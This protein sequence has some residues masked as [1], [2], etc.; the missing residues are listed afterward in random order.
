MQSWFYFVSLLLIISVEFLY[1]VS[2]LRTNSL[3]LCLAASTHNKYLPASE[4]SPNANRNIILNVHTKR[5]SHTV[6]CQGLPDSSAHL[7]SDRSRKGVW[8][9]RGT[10]EGKV[11]VFWSSRLE[12]DQIPPYL[13]VGHWYQS[14]AVLQPEKGAA[15]RLVKST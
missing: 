10:Q 6:V 14:V 1:W 9:F 3:K 11:R 2:Y 8:P 4:L 7:I 5:H 13:V 15:T 12:L